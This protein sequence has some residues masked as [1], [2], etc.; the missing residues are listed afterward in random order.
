MEEK[1]DKHSEN[2][3]RK[4]DQKMKLFLVHQYLMRETDEEHFVSAQDI[5]EYLQEN[6]GIYA[7]HRLP[8]GGGVFCAKGHDTALRAM[9]LFGSIDIC[10]RVCY[11]NY[12][13][14]PTAVQ[15]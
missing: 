4:Y 5:V 3:G 13:Y 1:Q 11:N 15:N 8:S 6:F 2:S 7:E 9:N 12:I 14:E 10:P